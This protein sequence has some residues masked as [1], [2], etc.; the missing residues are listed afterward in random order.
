MAEKFQLPIIDLDRAYTNRDEVAKQVV[1]ALENVG[2]LFID[3]V[4]DLDFDKLQEACNWFF[5]K[6]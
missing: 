3:S 1:D 5:S 4:P 2:F 6:P